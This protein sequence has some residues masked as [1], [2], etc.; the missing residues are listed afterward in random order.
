MLGTADVSALY[1]SL[2]A[3]SCSHPLRYDLTA[4]L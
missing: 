2:P 4:A 3:I 1:L